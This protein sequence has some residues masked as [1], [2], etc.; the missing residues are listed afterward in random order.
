MWPPFSFSLP[1]LLLDCLAAEP[2]GSPSPTV[3]PVPTPG[4]P[5]FFGVTCTGPVLATLHE[6]SVDQCRTTCSQRHDCKAFSFQDGACRLQS[7]CEGLN[8]GR[9]GEVMET[10]P[11]RPRLLR[12]AMPEKDV[13]C[14]GN[15]IVAHPNLTHEEC[16]EAC[17]N[18]TGCLLFTLETGEL[19]LH[20][21]HAMVKGV[22]HLKSRCPYRASM[23]HKEGWY[24][25]GWMQRPGNATFSLYRNVGR[26]VFDIL[27][28]ECSD[29]YPGTLIFYP[30]GAGPFGVVLFRGGVDGDLD[31]MDD[32]LETISSLGMIVLAPFAGQGRCRHHHRDGNRVWKDILHLLNEAVRQGQR[33]HPALGKANWQ[34]VAFVGHSMGAIGATTASI[35]MLQPGALAVADQVKLVAIV[36]SHDARHAHKIPEDVAVMFTTGS[37][38]Q[39]FKTWRAKDSFEGCRSHSKVL[40]NLHKAGHMEPVP[41]EKLHWASGGARL[42]WW[43]SQFLSCHVMSNADHC[44][45]VYGKGAHSMRHMHQYTAFFTNDIV[46]RN[47]VPQKGLKIRDEV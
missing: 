13:N 2:H 3:G 24:V 32:W 28:Y 6:L 22:C 26:G 34:R 12:C 4:P 31:H 1:L 29:G 8:R 18:T 40:A 39:H 20:H 14:P 45:A 17:G 33:L 10:L 44:E 30:E 11:S 36:A 38:D 19:S 7:I 43:S 16:C 37:E 23:A 42:N 35:E 47:L 27:G 25:T 15:N 41:K 21:K 46:R 5:P 9:A